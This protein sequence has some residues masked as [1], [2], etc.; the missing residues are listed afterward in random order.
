MNTHQYIIRHVDFAYNDEYFQTAFKSL[1]HIQ[2][3]FDDR[4]AAEAAYKNLVVAALKEEDLSNYDFG[5]GEASEEV[6][7]AV[8]AFLLEKTGQEYQVGDDLPDLSDDDL[9]QFAQLTGIVPYQLIEVESNQRFY[10]A[11]LNQ[12]QSYLSSYESGSLIY[13]NTPDFI[14]SS[15]FDWYF[16]DQIS[17]DLTGTLAELSEAPEILKQVIHHATGITY[18]EQE[19]RLSIEGH[20][21]SY[22]KICEINALLKE[23]LFEIQEKNLSELQ[24]LG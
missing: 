10:V 8:E 24:A 21:A 16:L 9:F 5:Y 6:Y 7:S 15:E 4:A 11:W 20:R 14:E 1:G 3:L 23:P 13:G 18:L 22:A 2:S 19:Q 12:E 17:T